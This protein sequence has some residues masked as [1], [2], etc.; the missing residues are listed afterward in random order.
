MVHFNQ[1][2]PRS[3][4]DSIP[5]DMKKQR[6][7]I[8]AR[9]STK[10]SQNCQRQIREL[11]EYAN[12]NEYE[13]TEIIQE[14]VSGFKQKKREGLERLLSICES[15]KVDKI[16][17][18]EI[19]RLGRRTGDLL[20]LIDSL[21]DKGIS[22]YCK[23]YNLETMVNGKR[24]PIAQFLFTLLGELARMESE[25]LSDRINSG[26]ENARSKGIKLGRQSGSVQSKID[27][28]KKHKDIPKYLNQGLSIRK[29]ALLAGVSPT[30]VQK[31]KVISLQN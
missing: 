3:E 13:V 2:I 9:V 12:R 29:V 21:T 17:V 26:L 1:N 31:V 27:F 22:V 8:Y 20:K 23:N 15:Q 5:C 11:T 10:K 7:I 25:N 16:L 18:S 30:T 28:L 14:A 4:K 6:V 24:N 19:S